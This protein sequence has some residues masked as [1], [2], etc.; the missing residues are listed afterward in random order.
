MG[1]AWDLLV[2]ERFT[3]ASR[4][5]YLRYIAADGL[6]EMYGI[7]GIMTR[8]QEYSGWRS[9]WVLAATDRF[10]GNGRAPACPVRSRPVLK[11]PAIWHSG[12]RLA[13]PPIGFI[14]RLQRVPENSGRRQDHRRWK[15]R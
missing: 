7:Q 2:A 4:T 14:F 15:P 10:L 5:E 8:I 6:A 11:A 12:P 13:G 1:R 9:S 3:G